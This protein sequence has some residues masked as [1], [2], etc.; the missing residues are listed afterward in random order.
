MV[1]FR[2]QMSDE[3]ARLAAQRI[4]PGPHG[5]PREQVSEVQRMRLLRAMAEVAAQRGL[6]PASVGRV[7]AQAGVSR[8]TF[9]D[10]FEDRDDCFVAVFDEAI[11][12]ATLKVETVVGQAGKRWVE[13]VRAGLF[14]LLCFFDEEPELARVCVVWA[15]GTSPEMLTR[16]SEVLQQL[17]DAVEHGRG[18]ARSRDPAPLTAE[19]VVGAVLSIVHS[20]LLD[21]D[22][23]PLSALLPRLMG[24]IVSP[25]LGSR[26]VARELSRPVPEIVSLKA[27]WSSTRDP[28][29]KL[30]M[31]V[32]YRTLRV[33]EAVR[34]HEGG[35]NREI[36]EEAG[37]TDQGQIS[38][39]LARLEDLELLENRGAGHERGSPNAWWLTPRGEA[40]E[41]ATRQQP[42]R[43]GGER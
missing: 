16:R 13:R 30:N 6:H 27:S 18:S 25:Y 41:R 40:M 2:A 3:Q 37:M 39:L 21:D 17:I 43:S 22:P 24:L 9:Y 8:R 15:L 36:G 29:R 5:L 35:S 19:A 20:R 11:A 33:L 7:T 1:A 32:T 38:K 28:M 34:V 31:R 26:A 23:A 10:L 4:R 12:R 42:A 14:A